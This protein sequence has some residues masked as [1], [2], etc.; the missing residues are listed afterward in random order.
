MERAITL[1]KVTKDR[2]GGLFVVYLPKRA[3]A[4]PGFQRGGGGGGGGGGCLRSGPIRKVG[5][6]GGGVR[7]RSDAFL[8][9]TE[10]TLPLIINVTWHSIH[11]PNTEANHLQR[12]RCAFEIRVKRH[13]CVDRTEKDTKC[14][15]RG[16]AGSNSALVRLGRG[17]NNFSIS[18]AAILRSVKL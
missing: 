15:V 12:E 17:H 1:T 14:C 2:V 8:W 9:H 18:K 7:F 6:G 10:N 4:H 5:R 13:L 16:V 3:V 11:V